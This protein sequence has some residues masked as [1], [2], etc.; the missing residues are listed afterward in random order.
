MVIFHNLTNNTADIL[1]IDAY[2]I[3]DSSR[4]VQYSIFTPYHIL[5]DIGQFA[6]VFPAS[7]LLIYG[8]VIPMLSKIVSDKNKFL[9]IRYR[10]FMIT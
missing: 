3:N 10:K 6:Q 4:N 5:L 8:S 9:I 7:I 2:I 1:I